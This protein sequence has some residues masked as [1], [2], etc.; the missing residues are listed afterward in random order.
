MAAYGGLRGAVNLC[1]VIISYQGGDDL[2]AF[3]AT[4]LVHI[5]G[6]VFLSLL[7]NVPT[8]PY[9]LNCL[10]ISSLSMA[11]QH[12]MNNCVHHI[13]AKRDRVIALLK[14]DRLVIEPFNFSKFRYVSEFQIFIGC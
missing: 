2:A 5:T 1:L 11:R 12:N 7:I 6:V 3:K 13:M 8:I 9:L 10:G 4:I 14:M